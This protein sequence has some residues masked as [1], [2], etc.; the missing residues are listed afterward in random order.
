VNTVAIAMSLLG[1]SSL[2]NGIGIQR[3]GDYLYFHHQ[4]LMSDTAARCILTLIILTLDDGDGHILRNVG[5][6]LH[7]RTA[8]RSGGLHFIVSPLKQNPTW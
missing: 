6:Q 4:E 5:Y 8:D 2:E 7:F 3:F 1:Q